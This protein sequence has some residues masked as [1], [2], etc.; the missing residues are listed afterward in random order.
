MD[1]LNLHGDIILKYNPENELYDLEYNTSK[2][3]VNNINICNYHIDSEFL[4]EVARNVTLNFSL[5]LT[6]ELLLFIRDYII[7]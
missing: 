5:E 3:I 6:E 4:I 7:D 2:I 1:M